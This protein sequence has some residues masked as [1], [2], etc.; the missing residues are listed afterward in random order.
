M[1]TISIQAGGR[2]SRMGQDKALMPFLGHTLIERVITRLAP[3]A[4]ELIITTN[5]PEAYRFL[6]RPLFPDLIP[7]RGALGGLYTA[8]ASATQP[9]VAVVACDMPFA[10]PTLL[11]W[12]RDVLLSEDLDV[13]IPASAEGLEPLHAVYRRE[14]CLPHIRAALAADQ[15]KLIS[16][17][18]QVRVRELSPQEC[19]R[20]DPGRLAFSN[21]NTPQEL[22]D[23]ETLA[24]QQDSNL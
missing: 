2:S 24:R 16:W 1:L 23:A 20:R 11:A 7:E 9:L 21:V 15:W 18:P 3:L 10:N 8:L 13:V 19:A 14:T 12:Q 22:I 5:Q 4:D 17:F 6:N